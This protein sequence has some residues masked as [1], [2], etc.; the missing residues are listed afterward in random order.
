M[1]KRSVYHGVPG[2][3]GWGVK[4]EGAQRATTTAPTK[5][6]AVD[7]A[8][9]LAKAQPLGQIKIHKQGGTIQTEH[10]YG[11]DPPEMKG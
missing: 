8:K 1:E 10:T 6:E 7:K 3:K 4:K 9:G 11:T 5:K 2:E